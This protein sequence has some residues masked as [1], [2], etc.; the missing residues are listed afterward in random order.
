VSEAPQRESIEKFFPLEFCPYRSV[1][2]GR[3]YC[4]ISTD[5]LAKEIDDLI[6]FNCPVPGIL[7][8]NDCIHLS[9]GTQ[10]KFFKPGEGMVLDIACLA[11]NR[12]ISLE[13]CTACPLYYP[14]G[15]PS[16]ESGRG[17]ARVV[18]KLGRE[19]LAELA[20]VLRPPAPPLRQLNPLAELLPCDALPDYD[21][22]AVAVCGYPS[23]SFL[24]LWEEAYAPVLKD[25]FNLIPVLVKL[26][27]LCHDA[28]NTAGTRIAIFD[29]SELHPY[30]T[31]FIGVALGLGMPVLLFA[32][33]GKSRDLGWFGLPVHFYRDV[34]DLKDKLKNALSARLYERKLP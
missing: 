3:L 31:L 21:E 19:A 9:L 15:K 6:C 11:K 28:R 22:K 12:R 29:L 7:G 24:T 5:L 33:S 34:S 26:E 20:P 1:S 8:R 18:V 30:V 17:S 13:D 23:A 2:A 4:E 16:E 25:D 27:E 32:P 10:V 14:R